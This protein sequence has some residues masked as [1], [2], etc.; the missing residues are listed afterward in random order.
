M[1]FKIPSLESHHRV[2][3]F[4]VLRDKIEQ[5]RRAA[6]IFQTELERNKM[7]DEKGRLEIDSIK[8]EVGQRDTPSPPSQRRW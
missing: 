8:K 1:P 5:Q 7:E 3:P 2:H 6:S 4:H